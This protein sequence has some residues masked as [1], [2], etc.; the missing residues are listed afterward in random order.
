[1][2]LYP[3]DMRKFFR[4]LVIA[5]AALPA[6]FLVAV[7]VLSLLDVT[8]DLDHLRG[9]VET[10][11]GAALGRDVSIKGPVRLQLSGWPSIEV[12]DVEIANVPGASAGVFFKAGIA[13]LQIGVLP[14]LRGE[15]QIGEI[16]AE[17]V[18]LNLEND[19]EG[20]ANWVFGEDAG[21]ET[22]AESRERLLS[23]AGLHELSLQQL[24][25]TYHDAALGKTVELSIDALYG[26]APPGKPMQMKLNG[27]LQEQ[28]YD[29]QL[30]GGPVDDLLDRS[31]LWPFTLAGEAFGKRIDASGSK[32]VKNKEPELGLKLTVQDAD[33]GAILERLGLVEGMEMTTGI[34]A[35]DVLLRGNTLNELVMQSKMIFA[36]S[37][38]EW[39][40]TL[41][42]TQKPLRVRELQGDITVKQVSEITM[43]LQGTIKGTPVRF[44]ITGAPLVEYMQAPEE[45]PLKLDIEMLDTRLSFDS[46]LAIP[47]TNR[48][49]T[50]MLDIEGKRLDKFNDL[51]KLDLPPLGPV[52]LTARLDVSKAG[53]DLSTLKV[54]VNE[55]GLEGRIN[56][57]TT[58]EKPK[59]DVDLV[60]NLFRV[61]DFDVKHAQA[62]R[63]D[64]DETADEQ[65]EKQEEKTAPRAAGE[66]R[67]LLSREVLNKFNAGLR[68]EAKKVT[69]GND[70]LGS[71]SLQLSLQDGRLALEPLR[72]DTPGGGVN[73][74]MSLLHRVDNIDFA[75]AASIDHLDYGILARRAEAGTDMGGVMSLDI[76]LESTAPGMMD[77]MA[78]ASGHFDFALLPEN[79][80][81][82]VFDMWAV[83]LIS[84]IA[85][86]V[87]KDEASEVN[88]I[89]VRLGLDAGLLTE[90][91]VFM[92]TTQMSVAGKVDI[93][94][95]SQEIDILMAPRAKRPEFFSLATPVK[96]NGSFDDFGVGVS[97]V[98]AARSVVSFI[99]SPIHVPIR[100]VFKKEVPA[101]GREA[102]ELAW[103]KT[104]DE[105][106]LAE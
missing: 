13:R 90:K 27:S 81:A 96:I 38:G 15:L 2:I 75:V 65:E 63:E 86:E 56:L 67:R 99:T 103:K 34:A 9:G 85:T 79:F 66:N 80:S 54:T 41:P 101:D 29:L 70:E 19:T 97:K 76:M 91:A 47:I 106:Y 100:R 18:V 62:G 89:V 78:N 95:T 6:L 39:V 25:L 12:Q 88:C 14:L 31:E 17:D 37:E 11:A 10:S 8:V 49:V 72:I 83:N 58:Q 30:S 45:L 5:L 22:D 84:A 46:K 48:D 1:M 16:A 23:F 98:R 82:E 26:K 69:S 35:I 42:N 7:L 44:L 60:S 55:S 3:V 64:P 59:V 33:I 102:C 92:D 40:I 68:L 28:T 87:D 93:D 36:V 73:V 32:V 51:L 20:R 4:W 105:D 74:D 52:S 50:M 53:Y 21:K 61:E 77:I 104:A 57:D 71:G 24:A 94:F 43:N